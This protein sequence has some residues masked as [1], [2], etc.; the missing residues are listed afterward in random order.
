FDECRRRTWLCSM[1]WLGR[2]RIPWEVWRDNFI[3]MRQ[4][5]G[6]GRCRSCLSPEL[7][8]VNSDSVDLKLFYSV[9]IPREHSLMMASKEFSCF[10]EFRTVRIGGLPNRQEFFISLFRCFA[11]TLNFRSTSKPEDYFGPIRRPAQCFLEVDDCLRRPVEFQQEI[12]AKFV[13]RDYGIR[14]LRQIVNRVFNRDCLLQ[15]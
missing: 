4:S 10:R 5:P 1:I 11:V 8:Q 6:P 3:Q 12:S 13:R 2:V 7:N 9:A 15:P 14:R